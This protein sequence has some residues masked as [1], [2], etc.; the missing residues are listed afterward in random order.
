M[1]AVH[2]VHGARSW[3]L[4]PTRTCPKTSQF[5]AEKYQIPL[6]LYLSM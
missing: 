2:I 4:A 6:A 5:N 3:G 1:N